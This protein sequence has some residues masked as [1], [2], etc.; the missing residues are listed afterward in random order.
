M[1]GGLHLPTLGDGLPVVITELSG[2]KRSIVFAGKDRPE[3]VTRTTTMR[4][5]QTWYPGAKRAST[6][7]LGLQEEPLTLA[8]WFRDPLTMFDGGA[9]ARMSLLRGIQQGQRL[10]RLEW[11]DAIVLHGRIKRLSFTP[12]RLQRVRYEIEF[13]VDFSFEPTPPESLIATNPVAADIARHL[14]VAAGHLRTALDVVRV[15]A[16]LRAFVPGD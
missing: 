8:G 9:Q 16:A 5:V 2:A 3:P 7:V 11:G 12:Q 14:D 1:L 6:Q 4:T 15:G 10:C 13:E